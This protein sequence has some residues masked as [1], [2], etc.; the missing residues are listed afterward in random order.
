MLV[1]PNIDPVIF[2]LGPLKVQW[3]GLMYLLGF[4]AAYGLA[5]ARKNRIGWT[6]EDVSDLIFYAAIGVI[7]G[8]RLGYVIFY[9]LGYYL[10]HPLQILNTT[11]GGMSFHGGF[12]GVAVGTYLFSRK[13]NMKFLG[14]ADFV[15]PLA[16]LG[17]F[18]GRVGN[19]INQELWGKPTDLPWAVI[20]T[21][22]EKSLPRHPSMLYEA[23][24][25][26]LVLFTML[27][28]YS[29]RERLEG[30]VAG[31]FLLGYGIFRF[32]IELVREP[33]NHI[34]YVALSWVTVGQIY[35]IPMLLLGSYLFFRKKPLSIKHNVY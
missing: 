12:I 20:F 16:P 25:E 22:D 34:G 35:C 18:F 19:F 32:A 11:G 28:V 24:L 15:A 30:R 6:S 4:I 3:Y 13:K 33:D 2:S 23:F 1:H 10:E 27:W 7:V 9:K 14:L 5:N 26:G 29:R 21:T 31:L 8:G 17:L